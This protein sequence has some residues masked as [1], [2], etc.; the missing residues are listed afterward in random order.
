MQGCQDVW[1][2]PVLA[3]RHRDPGVKDRSLV[4]KLESLEREFTSGRADVG[5]PGS[6]QESAFS[7]LGS[8][9]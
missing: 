3:E 9:F 4:H 7:H 1:D 6:H 2:K 8:A 5:A